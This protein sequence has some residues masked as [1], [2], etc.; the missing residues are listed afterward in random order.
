MRRFTGMLVATAAAAPAFAFA[1][2]PLD[3]GR[4]I[5][6]Q[7]HARSPGHASNKSGNVAELKHA[8]PIGQAGGYAAKF[9]LTARSMVGT[10]GLTGDRIRFEGFLSQPL[11][12]PAGRDEP[13]TTVAAA[14]D[15]PFMS[16][17]GLE[18]PYLSAQH[19]AQTAPSAVDRHFDAYLEAQSDATTAVE[20]RNSSCP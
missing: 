15:F 20:G 9:E 8:A 14:Y 19:G 17:R 7:I 3:T 11:I 13:G 12:S 2:T 16:E 5:E 6:P 1:P 18:P 4:V 10:V